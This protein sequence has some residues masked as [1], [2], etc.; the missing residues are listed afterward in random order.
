MSAST[1]STDG[2]CYEEAVAA[3]TSLRSDGT[4]AGTKLADE[5]ESCCSSSSWVSCGDVYYG[6]DGRGSARSLPLGWWGSNYYSVPEVWAS[7][8]AGA[9]YLA[10]TDECG[11]MIATN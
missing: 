2:G 11:A 10:P 4:S 8:S 9:V 5:C 1:A 3:G 7:S 6:V